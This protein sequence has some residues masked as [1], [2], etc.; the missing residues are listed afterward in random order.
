MN[1]C[2]IARSLADGGA[3]NVAAQ[4]TRIWSG[5]NHR[6]VV[7][8]Q[9]PPGERDYPNAVAAR[10]VIPFERL[11]EKVIKELYA[12]YKFDI[13]VFNGGNCEDNFKEVVRS[14]KNFTQAKIILILHHVFSNW[15]QSTACSQEFV[16][17][18]IHRE[19]DMICPVE[20]LSALW[21]HCQGCNAV[22]MANPVACKPDKV[23]SYRPSHRLVWSGKVWLECKRFNWMVEIFTALKR[24]YEDAELVVLGTS[25]AKREAALLTSLPPEVARAIHFKGFVKSTREELAKSGL[26]VHT[27]NIE[28]APQVIPEAQAVGLPSVVYNLPVLYAYDETQ[29][30]VRAD[31]IDDSVEK[32]SDLF[33]HPEKMSALSQAAFADAEIACSD[34]LCAKRWS[35]LF[36][37]LADDNLL[38][39]YLRD[40]EREFT[41]PRAYQALV[42][43]FAEG[44]HNFVTKFLPDIFRMRRLRH[45]MSVKYLFG[46]ILAKLGVAK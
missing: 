34:E 2:F 1:I 37:A 7:V 39:Q 31:S 41:T 10:E 4:L 19:I 6:V 22:C 14:I 45:R 44:T 20:R 36:A 27:A 9:I 46:R 24:R 18:E 16:W 42:R 38:R 21:W 5:L 33:D 25:D 29:G 35:D 30:V 28:A 17:P 32:I 43:E 23:N 40:A 8:S 13:V 15:L 26:F 3:E 12:K 11:D